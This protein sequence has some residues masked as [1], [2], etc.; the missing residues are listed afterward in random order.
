MTYYVLLTEPGQNIQTLATRLSFGSIKKAEEYA[1]SIHKSFQP[2]VVAER[3]TWAEPTRGKRADPA[4]RKSQILALAPGDSVVFFPPPG[5]KVAG[6]MSSI[7]SSFDAEAWAPYSQ[8]VM[9]LAAEGEVG[10]KV[11][12]VTR[13][14]D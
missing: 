9:L 13:K 6:L 8:K 4:S 12:R 7:A 11:V 5:T 14:E 10:Q 1:A 2:I 3:K